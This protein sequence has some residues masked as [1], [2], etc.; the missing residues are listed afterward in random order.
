M[1][2]CQGTTML[3]Q[4]HSVNSQTETTGVNATKFL[5]FSQK[6]EIYTNKVGLLQFTIKMSQIPSGER[7]KPQGSKL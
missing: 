1:N 2:G 4:S 6:P 7:P 3:G 5:F